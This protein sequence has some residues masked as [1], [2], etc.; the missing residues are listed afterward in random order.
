MKFWLLQLWNKIMTKYASKQIVKLK[1]DFQEVY[2]QL[3]CYKSWY[4]MLLIIWLAQNKPIVTVIQET[5]SEKVLEITTVDYK[6]QLPLT[7]Y[8][9]ILE[10]IMKPAKEE[11]EPKNLLTK[12]ET[13]NQLNKFMLSQVLI[14]Y[15]ED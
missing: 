9:G 8:M 15:K 2:Y 3:E 14:N 10:N 7:E 4:N 12:E 5:H 6:F 1:K 13:T 11:R